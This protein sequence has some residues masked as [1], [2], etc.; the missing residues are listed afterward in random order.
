MR[1]ISLLGVGLVTSVGKYENAYFGFC[2]TLES[3]Y[4]YFSNGDVCKMTLTFVSVKIRC[5]IVSCLCYS[6]YS[7]LIS[8]CDVTVVRCSHANKDYS[9]DFVV[10]LLLH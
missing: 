4:W 5:L 8:C 2:W 6:C 7:C 1:L 3:K 10:V 9:I